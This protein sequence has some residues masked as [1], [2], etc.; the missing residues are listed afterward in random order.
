MLKDTLVFFCGEFGRTPDNGLRGGGKSYGRDHN[1][2]AMAMWFAG[3]G[4][5]GGRTVG[6]TDEL[7][8]K[9]VENVHPLRDVH[10]TLLRLLGLD[11]NRLTFYHAGRFKQL[12][13][14]GGKVIEELIA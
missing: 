14:F 1:A 3:G 5:P 13:Q 6:A 8:M 11:D 2:Q 7:G 4:V 10:V 12:S 9:A